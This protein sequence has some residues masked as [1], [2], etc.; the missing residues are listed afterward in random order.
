M[1]PAHSRGAAA[2]RGRLAGMF[3]TKLDGYETQ[4][5]DEY[6]KF[7][8]PALKTTFLLPRRWKDMHLVSLFVNRVGSKVHAVALI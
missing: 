1:M 7:G 5:L 4:A 8:F 3:R 2:S 6:S